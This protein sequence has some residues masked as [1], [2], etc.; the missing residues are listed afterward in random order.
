MIK[1]S[2]NVTTPESISST[3]PNNSLER[4]I[5]NLLSSSDEVFQYKSNAQLEFE[6]NLR[7]NIIAAARDLNKSRF[8]FR[9]FRQSICNEDYWERTKNG[10]FLLKDDVKPASA[11]KDILINSSK[12]GSECAT[13]IVIIYYKAL[14]NVF[15][16]ELFNQ[17][18]TKIFLMNWHYTDEDIDINPHRNIT[19]PIPGDCVYFDNPDVDPVTPQWQGENTIDLGNGTYYGHGIGI[20]KAESVIEALN[21]KRKED[22]TKSAYQLDMVTRPNFNHLADIYLDYSERPQH[23]AIA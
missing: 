19:T 15:P 7:V 8:S 1:I 11:I 22:A 23:T 6:I 5:I 21:T 9:I 14:V 2:G 20:R 4:K 10:G 17:V 16:E 18:F 12:Y 3:Y 13:A